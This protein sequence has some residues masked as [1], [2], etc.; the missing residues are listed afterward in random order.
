M[1]PGHLVILNKHNLILTIWGKGGGGL[2]QPVSIVP[3]A[4]RCLLLLTLTFT[5]HEHY[6]FR[7]KLQYKW[8]QAVIETTCRGKESAAPSNTFL[9]ITKIMVDK[10]RLAGFLFFFFLVFTLSESK[11]LK[12]AFQSLSQTFPASN[13]QTIKRY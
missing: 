2:P 1:L 3:R 7:R 12:I 8:Y 4:L 5:L 11:Q 9:R 10:P 6:N 13:V